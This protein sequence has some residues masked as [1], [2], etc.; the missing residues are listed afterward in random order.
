MRKHAIVTAATAAALLLGALPVQAYEA[1]DWLL[2]VGA[3]YVDPKSGNGDI[4]A[5]EGGAAVVF[6]GTYFFTPNLALEVLAA[7]PFSHDIE[8][9]G[10]NPLSIPGGTKLGET[11]HLPPTVSVQYHFMPDGTF[12]PYAG[13]GLNYTLF[14]DEDTTGPIAG[15]DL[16][17]DGSF[18]LALQLG[19]DVDINDQWILN[20][21]LRWIDIDTDADLDGAELE[22]VEI[23]P[24]VYSVTLGYRF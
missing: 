14:F 20:F 5:V 17:L 1:G 19:A 15:T 10:S 22:T 16:D 6:N 23:D 18:G 3:G 9:D 13:I 24:M 7:T 11:K 12:H 2:R 21:D 4:A 8:A